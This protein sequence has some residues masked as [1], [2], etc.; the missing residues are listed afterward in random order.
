[1]SLRTLRRIAI[2]VVTPIV[3]LIVVALLITISTDRESA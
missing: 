1:M 2:A 3:M